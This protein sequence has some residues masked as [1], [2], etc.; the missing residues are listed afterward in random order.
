MHQQ[1]YCGTISVCITTKREAD[2]LLV[3]T[4]KLAKLNSCNWWK[5]WNQT[6]ASSSVVFFE[7]VTPALLCHSFPDLSLV[8]ELNDLEG[9]T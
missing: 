4:K 7:S 1:F 2:S 3:R 6:S 9:I 8:F 5:Y